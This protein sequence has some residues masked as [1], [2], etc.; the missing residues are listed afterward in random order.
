MAVE[1]ILGG[2]QEAADNI[3]ARSDRMV[4]QLMET[5]NEL[6]LRL[7]SEI[8]GEKLHGQVLQQ[9]TGK[10]AGSIRAQ[11]TTQEGTDIIG[12]VE[13][14]GGVA[15]YGKLHEYG[16]GPYD[17]EVTRHIKMHYGDLEF[18]KLIHSSGFPE[19]SFMR[20]T[21][22]EFETTIVE[23]MQASLELAASG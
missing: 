10:L 5:M 9:R 15:W 13:G 11:P 1:L 23:A 22:S 21:L 6:M 17:Y 8:V 14:G 20:S 16:F 7:Q 12:A 19:R 4:A 2:G 18:K 3:R